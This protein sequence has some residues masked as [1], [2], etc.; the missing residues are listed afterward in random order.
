MGPG[1]AGRKAWCMGPGAGIDVSCVIM[2]CLFREVFSDWDYFLA[3]YIIILLSWVHFFKSRFL[4]VLCQPF[5]WYILRIKAEPINVV[6]LASYV[7]SYVMVK[8]KDIRISYWLGNMRDGPDTAL[9][10]RELIKDIG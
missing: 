10:K 6:R 1:P 9:P 3:T 7:T 8:H 2:A 5:F 4:T